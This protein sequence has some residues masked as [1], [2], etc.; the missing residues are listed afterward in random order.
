MNKKFLFVALLVAAINAISCYGQ[1]KKPT[2]MV[3][4]ADVWCFENGFSDT[5]ETQ[6]RT[7]RIPDYER[8]YQEN[9]DLLIVT[10]KIGELMAERGFPLKDMSSTI[11]DINRSSTED[12]MTL[13]RAGNTIA[14]TPLEK[15]LNRAKADILVEVTWKVST[16]G[17]KKSVTYTLRGIDA[18]T[19]KQVAAA[20][21]TGPQSFSAEVPVLLEEAVLENMDNF[22]AQLQAHFDDLLENGR[23]VIVNLRVFDNGT[24][25][26]FEDEYDGEELT[27][28]IDDWMAQ[29]TVNH[30]YNLT[31][32]GSTSMHF[33]QV[34]IPLYR[35][36]GM[37][38]DTRHFGTQL[39][40][41]LSKPPYNIPAKIITK[42][43]GRGDIILG[44]K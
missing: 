2:L 4:P 42:G 25:L 3:M 1:A 31:D 6:G 44:E 13:S 15:L 35:E 28:V 22:I 7:V 10:T 29:N 34:R 30:R 39:R 37:P 24:G 9:A 17:P 20:Q 41:F 27:D 33:E 26:S 18:Y 16:V 32:A 5:Y 14:E 8:A 19:N 36:N 11:R 38:M 12:E 21:G 43:L 40:R 23:E